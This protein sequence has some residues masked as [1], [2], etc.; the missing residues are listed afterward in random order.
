MVPGSQV[1]LP[2]ILGSVLLVTAAAGACSSPAPTATSGPATGSVAG[3]TSSNASSRDFAAH[4]TVGGR[5]VY[6]ECHGLGRPTIVLQSG[7]GNAGDIW[8]VATAHPPAVAP[9][10]A[11]TNRVC[12]YDRPGTTLSLDA[13]GNP[14]SSAQPGRSDQ[15]P[16]PRTATAVV[17]EWHDLLTTAEVPGP[18]LLVGHSIGGLFTLLYARTY[19]DQV[20]GVVL[21]DATPPAFAS[22]LPPQS[23]TLLKASLNAPSS[24]PGYPYEGYDLDDILTAIDTA[25]ALRPAPTTLL[26]AGQLQQVSDPATQEF[27][28]DAAAVQDQ[29]RDQLAASIP[30]ATTKVVTDATHYIQV[31][32]PDAVIEAVRAVANKAP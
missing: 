18:F 22:L 5:Q 32:R 14:L 23:L 6:L 20:A 26:F 7:Y 13:A 1:H 19:P 2:R 31:E 25:P 21:V 3:A 30:G 9:G 28:K 17:T 24:I 29:A 10:L 15:V 4:L 12:V 8:S 27:L 16:M 11:A